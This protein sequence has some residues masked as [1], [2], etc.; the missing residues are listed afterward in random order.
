M[1][2][3][4]IKKSY[5]KTLFMSV[6]NLYE[7]C[8]GNMTG[9][10]DGQVRDAKG[11][12]HKGSSCFHYSYTRFTC[13]VIL[14]VLPMC[15]SVCL[16]WFPV[17][18]VRIPQDPLLWYL[19]SLVEYFFQ[20]WLQ[21]IKF[22]QCIIDFSWFGEKQNYFLGFNTSFRRIMPNGWQAVC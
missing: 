2:L 6:C 12:N 19:L 7:Q 17:F 15:P 10:T 5:N 14:S 13:S 22:V 20:Y 9:I 16:F 3:W 11:W 18:M 1:Q 21:F 8:W 4:N